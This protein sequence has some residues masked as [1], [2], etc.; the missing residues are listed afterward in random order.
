MNTFLVKEK[1]RSN[2]TDQ[3]RDC[4]KEPS[5]S[6]IYLDFYN[7]HEPPFSITP[8]PAF[9][10]MSSSH[11]AV[12]EKISYGIQV[13]MGFL[14]LIGEVGTGKTTLC[15]MILDELKGKGETVYIINPSLSSMDLI[16]SI[17]DDLGIG[18][19][20]D[21]SKKELLDHLNRFLLTTSKEKPVVII[22]DDAQT[23]TLEGLETLRLL[24]NLET[25]KEKLLQLVLA[26]QQ[27]LL[28]ILSKPEIR[29][30]QQRIAIRCQLELLE[31][32]EIQG[33]ISHRLFV[34]GDKG[35]IRFSTG[36]INKI[37]KAS[38]GIPRLINKICDYALTA[39][40]VSNSLEIK[41]THI[42]QALDELK[43]NLQK[44]EHKPPFTFSLYFNKRIWL[45]LAL[46]GIGILLL[47]GSFRFNNSVNT[48]SSTPNQ[49]KNI[50]PSP[51]SIP[52]ESVKD[53][54][55]QGIDNFIS[56]VTEKSFTVS[57]NDAEQEQAPIAET[58]E[59]PCSF[60]LQLASFKTLRAT[61]RAVSI[62]KGKNID[63]HWNALD[64]GEQN[65]WYR[66]YTGRFHTKEAAEE[67]K[68]GKGLSEGIIIYAPWTIQVAVSNNKTELISKCS[69]LKSMGF[70]CVL[71]GDENSRY[72]IT[73]GAFKTS[74]SAMKMAGELIKNGFDAKII[75]E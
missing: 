1:W 42:E 10:Y 75:F 13:R 37:Y 2:S 65:L 16:Q 44:G 36:A 25:D 52:Q 47:L 7:L 31:K 51:S 69:E 14:L 62:Y 15:R 23:M 18:Y 61:L 4:A 40:Y 56:N 63:V 24:S 33:Y 5:P 57:E 50:S 8:D 67:F 34:A 66:L 70:D 43:N 73:N 17:L 11:K 60:I 41:K 28:D 48:V 6:R 45:E 64:L 12:I 29:Q 53:G 30:L 74:E 26:G 68:S 19:P 72:K 21:A 22:I 49:A 32:T 58:M 54:S 59:S 71:T 9:L 3:V 20:A 35:N 46:L 55:L 27:E 39:G 38:L